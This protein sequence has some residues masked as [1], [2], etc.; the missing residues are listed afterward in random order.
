MGGTTELKG[1]DLAA[2]IDID[3]LRDGEPLLGHAA[4]EGVVLIK[5]GETC[6]AVGA[7]CSHYS[8]PL[9]EGIVSGDTIRCPWHHARFDIATGAPH[10][11]PG[12]NPIPCFDLVREGS[13]VRVAGKRAPTP[14]KRPTKTPESVVIVGSGPAGVVLAETLR[15][16]GYEGSI[17][18]VGEEGIPIDRPNLSKDYLAGTAPE[19]WMPL[20]DE[21]AL[22]ERKIDLVEARATAIDLNHKHVALEGAKS[23]GFGALVIATG[24]SPI[25]LPIPGA[26]LP[27][28]HLIRTL[29]DSRGIIAG[30]S[31]AKRA[32][33]IG[34]GFIGLEAA[35]ALRARGLEV[36]VVL[37]E[38]VALEHVLGEALGKMVA[39][40]HIEHG[41]TFVRDTVS[42]IHAS[43]VTL[44]GGKTLDADLV[45]MGV[46]VKPRIDLASSAGLRVENGIVV[47]EYLRAA[48]NVYAI[49]DVARF[50]WGPEKTL[51]RVEHWVHAERMGFAAARNILG[52]EEPFRLAPFF[53]SQNY[54]VPVNYV[55]AGPWDA[56]QIIGDPAKRDVLAVY[57]L[58]GRAV[59]LASVYRDTDSLRFEEL[60]ERG[61]DAGIEALLKPSA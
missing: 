6:F 36:T 55:G 32:V 18:I 41:V 13:L 34:G 58:R 20:R 52:R 12:L 29:A 11:G 50:P 26:D 3:T 60:L 43:S 15:N 5:R 33:V 37:R 17:S 14:P 35:A 19:E 53:W 1:P 57:R 56:I 47:D 21:A 44:T 31:G 61:D 10:G 42:A 48:P 28:V 8:G 30:L 49:G 46:G 7:T 4:G 25:R 45:V 39:A 24:A 22:R 27:H 59:A 23:I 40:I 38:T 51:V 2:G 54:D 16:E 9:G